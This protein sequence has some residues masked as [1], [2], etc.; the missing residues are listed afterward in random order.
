MFILLRTDIVWHHPPNS[1]SGPSVKAMAECNG[2]EARAP[3]ALRPT[4]GSGSPTQTSK[5]ATS[6]RAATLK[7]KNTP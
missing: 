4:R 7:G 1:V 2:K 5:G 3:V 6:V